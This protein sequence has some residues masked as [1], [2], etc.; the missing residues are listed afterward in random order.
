ML[1]IEYIHHINSGDEKG[2]EERHD[3]AL[4]CM[5]FDEIDSLE[6]IDFSDIDIFINEKRISMFSI[7]RGKMLF[8]CTYDDFRVEAFVL[9]M[10]Y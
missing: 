1:N 8:R 6:Q 7:I 4:Y 5:S 2:V 9:G 3:A 10:R